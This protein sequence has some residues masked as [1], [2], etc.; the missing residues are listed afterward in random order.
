MCLAMGLAPKCHFCLETPKWES[1]NSLNWDSH[2]FGAHNFVC[3]PLIEMKS[4]VKLQYLSRSF[5]RYVARHLNVRKS[6][7]FLTFSGRESN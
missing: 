7:Q 3:K 6:G 1:Q 4:K 2:N 5:Q